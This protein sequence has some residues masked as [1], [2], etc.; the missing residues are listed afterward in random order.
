MY[1]FKNTLL[2]RLVPSDYSTIGSLIYSYLQKL[3][4]GEKVPSIFAD[5]RGSSVMGFIEN[6]IDGATF[7]RKHDD[8]EVKEGDRGQTSGTDDGQMLESSGCLATDGT[9][10]GR[11][12]LKLNVT[13][14]IYLLCSQV[15]PVYF[16][17]PTM[18]GHCITNAPRVVIRMRRSGAPPRPLWIIPSLIGV[19]AV[20]DVGLLRKKV[21]P[22]LISRITFSD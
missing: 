4:R 1:S 7:C 14:H 10:K 22:I 11:D 21:R 13:L 6:Q 12:S 2:S 18:R 5:I 17:S 3:N 15:S 19:I 20:R 16:P 9:G 8:Q